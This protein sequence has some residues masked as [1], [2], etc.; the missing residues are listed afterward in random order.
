MSNH[1]VPLAFIITL[2]PRLGPQAQKST[3]PPLAHGNF[4][5]K[6]FA[7]KPTN[8]PLLMLGAAA[9]LSL[10]AIVTLTSCKTEATA[11]AAAA[12]SAPTPIT[13]DEVSSAQ[14]SWG[15]ALVQ[16]G[17][18]G[19]EGKDPRPVAQAA[20][21]KLYHYASTPVLFKP[22]LTHG[23]QTFRNTAEGALAYFAGGDPAFPDDKGFALKPWTS[24]RFQTSGFFADG[25]TAL[26]QGNVWVTDTEG[27]EV[28]VD[29][30]FGYQR[31]ADGSLRIVLHHSSL[32]YKPAAP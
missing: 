1:L 8:R 17:K 5:A 12:V 24:V 6:I 28:M 31:S 2:V 25:N 21:A 11:P 9:L 13:L 4:L 18:A 26:W 27:G 15:E 19:A 16:I 30:S 10:S 23:H 20:I 7:M 14:K 22:T 3:L 32:P 29:K